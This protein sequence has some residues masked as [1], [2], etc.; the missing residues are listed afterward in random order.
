MLLMVCKSDTLIVAKAE[1]VPSPAAVSGDT[2]LSSKVTSRS[3]A[4]RF[5]PLEL[6]PCPGSNRTRRIELPSALGWASNCTVALV[7]ASGSRGLSGISETG[8]PATP[9]GET[10]RKKRDTPA[11]GL[12]KLLAEET[13]LV[14]V[15]HG[16]VTLAANCKEPTLF[17]CTRA[18]VPS[19][20][21]GC[22]VV[23]FDWAMRLGAAPTPSASSRPRPPVRQRRLAS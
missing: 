6:I 23:V 22:K 4:S 14:A 7:T 8:S 17:H 19:T 9:L 13:P 20:T 15:V 3:S 21:G 11:S 10:T 5:T 18:F 2:P 12:V 16:P 1:N